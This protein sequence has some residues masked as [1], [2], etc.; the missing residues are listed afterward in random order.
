MVGGAGPKIGRGGAVREG[1]IPIFGGVKFPHNSENNSEICAIRADSA[2]GDDHSRG[3][4]NVLQANSLSS[5]TAIPFPKNSQFSRRKQRNGRVGTG[6]KGIGQAEDLRLAGRRMPR[7]AIKM[8]SLRH[9]VP[10]T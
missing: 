10:M 5:R 2:R 3:N 7:V 4:F 9:G 1:G 6:I 8:R